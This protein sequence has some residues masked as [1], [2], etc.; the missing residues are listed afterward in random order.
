[1]KTSLPALAAT[2]LVLPLACATPALASTAVPRFRDALYVATRSGE[3]PCCPCW[4]FGDDDAAVAAAAPDVAAV[5]DAGTAVEASAG[6]AHARGR[7]R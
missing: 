2:C 1:M 7:T 4:P 6:V 5:A 3:F